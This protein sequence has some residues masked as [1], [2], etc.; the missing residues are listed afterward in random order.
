MTHVTT[1]N[2]AG[3]PAPV[4]HNNSPVLDIREHLQAKIA[5]YNMLVENGKVDA[6]DA[7]A[8]NEPFA[9]E[10]QSTWNY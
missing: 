8:M 4:Y 6:H 7:T 1:H 5:R 3:V 2:W 9:G 10:R